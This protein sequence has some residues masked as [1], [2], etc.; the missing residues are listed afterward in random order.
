M[1]LGLVIAG[2][3]SLVFAA[4][5]LVGERV[6]PTAHPPRE[7]GSA[8]GEWKRR[9]EIREYLTAI[10]ERYAEGHAVA[11][12]RVDFYL[13]ERDVAI[14]FDAMTYFRLESSPTYAILAEH[15]MPGM[16]LG[17][18]L[19]FETPDLQRSAVDATGTAFAAL[20]LDPDASAAEVR[21]AYRERVKRIHPDRGG[22]E[23]AFKR[24]R[25]AYTEARRRAA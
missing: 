16:H 24:L 12:H 22:D 15:E 9:K 14:T 19:P 25:A 8:D 2:A 13:P 4:L 20:G 17:E 18:R 6:F 5:F 7:S 1:L 10:G 21:A 23:E 11:G 3:L